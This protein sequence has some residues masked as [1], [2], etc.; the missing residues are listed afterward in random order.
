MIVA[1]EEAKSHTCVVATD[2]DQPY[3]GHT[4]NILGCKSK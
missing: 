2:D 3:K 4:M 1:G